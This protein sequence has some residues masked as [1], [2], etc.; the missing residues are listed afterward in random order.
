[1]TRLRVIAAATILLLAGCG[2]RDEPPGA[3][4][5]EIAGYGILEHERV[6]MRTDES[7]SVGAKRAG[8]PGLRLAVQTDRIP[9][10]P[11]LSYGLAFR[12][13]GAPTEEGRIRV[14]LRT[15]NPCVLKKS[16]ETVYHNDTILIVKPGELR[17]IGGYIPASEEENHCVGDPQPGT[18]TFELYLGERKLADKAFH[19]YKD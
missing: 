10:R 12:L 18:S 19:L 8:A 5:I 6:A 3:Q 14:V 15:S 11:G 17:H 16:G 4:S 1:M 7:S 13:T 9:L 2:A